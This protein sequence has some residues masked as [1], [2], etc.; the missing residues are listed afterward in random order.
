MKTRLAFT[1]IEML[2]VVAVVTV[3]GTA[4]S[5]SV[6]YGIEVVAMFQN[7]VET[8]RMLLDVQQSWQHAISDTE[9]SDWKTDGTVFVAG[10]VQVAPAEG[11]LVV[12]RG[13]KHLPIYIPK[14]ATIRFTIE[15]EA[16][17]PDRAVLT[18]H[19]TSTW[20]NQQRAATV[21]MVACGER[22]S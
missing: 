10:D 22:P 12:Q 6:V 11:K 16:G 19:W 14:Q 2:V 15:H 3:I 20:L 1:L 17:F 5:K 13:E 21:R 8:C 7:R 18:F 9:S 4:A